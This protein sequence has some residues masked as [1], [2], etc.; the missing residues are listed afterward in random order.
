MSVDGAIDWLPGGDVGSGIGARG[1]LRLDFLKWSAGRFN[2][3]HLGLHRGEGGVGMFADIN[4]RVLDD[5]RYASLQAGVRFSLPAL[6]G[7]FS[8]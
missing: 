6:A 5:A 2:G 8:F 4:V 1:G 7:F 3:K